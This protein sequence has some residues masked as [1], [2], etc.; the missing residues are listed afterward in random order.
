VPEKLLNFKE[1]QHLKLL[2][3]NWRL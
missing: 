1:K 3:L 2:V